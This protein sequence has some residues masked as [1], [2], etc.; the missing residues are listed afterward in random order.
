[1]PTQPDKNITPAKGYI[2]SVNGQIATV[3]IAS[4]NFPALYEI[5]TSPKDSSIIM[6]VFYSI[7]KYE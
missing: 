6:E 3:E 5:L 1:M 2:R 7:L 4:E